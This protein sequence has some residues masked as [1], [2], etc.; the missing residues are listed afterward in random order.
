VDK[1]SEL[2]R[3]LQR[4]CEDMLV[5]Y[6]VLS[7]DLL[8]LVGAEDLVDYYITRGPYPERPDTI[9]DTFLLSGECLYNCE[10][11][12]KGTVFQVAPLVTVVQISEDLGEAS[13]HEFLA[14]HIKHSGGLST[15][16]RDKLTNGERLRRF[17]RAVKNALVQRLA[18]PPQGMQT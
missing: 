10:V 2:L 14:L 8:E 16:V 15:V 9:A 12:R 7:R 5:D 6:E 18:R 4:L 11:K 17:S 3:D 13:G 1:R